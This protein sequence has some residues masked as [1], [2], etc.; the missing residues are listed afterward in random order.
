[1]GLMESNEDQS[2]CDHMGI[3]MSKHSEAVQVYPDA[4][5]RCTFWEEFG[6]SN[7]WFMLD[8]DNVVLPVKD[9]QYW[10][11]LY[12]QKNQMGK[13]GLALGAWPEDFTTQ[14]PELQEN[15]DAMTCKPDLLT[16]FREM[17]GAMEFSLP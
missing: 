17:G 3:V 8:E 16:D 7:Y 13:A 10:A 9:A 4:P 12:L 6:K 5:V 1:M 15:M 11:V 2:T 14:Y